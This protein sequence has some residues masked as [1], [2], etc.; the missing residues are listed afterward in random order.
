MYVYIG[1]QLLT[2]SLPIFVKFGRMIGMTNTIIMLTHMISNYLRNLVSVCSSAVS[3]MLPNFKKIS[4]VDVKSHFE[5]R[6]TLYIYICM[7]VCIYVCVCHT[8]LKI[9]GT[10][11]LFLFFD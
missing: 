7:N 11:I 5:H 2:P 8:H 4:E 10:I 9:T 3:I 6:M 1:S